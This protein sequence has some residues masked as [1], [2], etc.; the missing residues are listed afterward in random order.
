MGV[1][2]VPAL[3]ILQ[4]LLI[5][6]RCSPL[7]Q[8]QAAAFGPGLRRGSQK[9]L[10]LCMGQHDGTDIPAVHNDIMGLGQLTLTLQQKRPHLRIGRHH[11]CAGRDLGQPDLGCDV[12]PVQMHM[13]QSV[14]SI[15]ELHADLRQGGNDSC[16]V[17]RIDPLVQHIAGNG[18]VD[19]A[20]VHIEVAQRR[21]G[22]PG[23][24]TLPGTGGAVYGNADGIHE[25]SLSCQRSVFAAGSGNAGSTAGGPGD[26]EIEAAGVG[27]HIQNFAC[28]V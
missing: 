13:L 16:L 8:F 9:D 1:V 26:L 24:R 18:P 14:R 23:Q 2:P 4:H 7:L 28:K 19:G 3:D 12:L 25:N 21:G 10:H 15:G 11:R 20:G 17:C 22:F 5:G 6:L 27:V